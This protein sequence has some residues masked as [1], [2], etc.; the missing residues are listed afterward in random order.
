MIIKIIDRNLY[1]LSKYFC[2]NTNFETA[3]RL[4]LIDFRFLTT[5]MKVV[6]NYLFIDERRNCVD[7]DERGVIG[8]ISDFYLGS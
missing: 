1:K 8:T 3:I 7:Y 5:H 4:L 6:E 2:I